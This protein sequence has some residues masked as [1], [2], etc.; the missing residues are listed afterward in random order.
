MEESQ[1]CGAVI[2]DY[3][4]G[5]LVVP[6]E[7]I[8]VEKPTTSADIYHRGEPKNSHQY[9]SWP[10]FENTALNWTSDFKTN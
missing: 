7:R 5:C 10:T 6:S 8:M 1:N 2:E 9:P 4:T 3:H